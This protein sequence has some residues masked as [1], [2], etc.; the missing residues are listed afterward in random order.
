LAR[1]LVRRERRA[2]RAKAEKDAKLAA[3]QQRRQDAAAAA[4]RGEPPDL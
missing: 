2:A 4:K 1:K 3:L